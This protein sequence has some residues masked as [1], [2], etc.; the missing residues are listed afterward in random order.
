MKWDSF[1]NGKCV[2]SMQYINHVKKW[3]CCN[4]KLDPDLLL[5]LHQLHEVLCSW[6]KGGAHLLHH[7]LHTLKVDAWVCTRATLSVLERLQSHTHMGDSHRGAAT[8]RKQLYGDTT[9]DA[10]PTDISLSVCEESVEFISSFPYLHLTGC[11]RAFQHQM[12]PIE[13]PLIFRTDRKQN[14]QQ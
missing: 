9:H 8:E 14:N 2:H 12:I 11:S 6:W 10:E 1:H 3:I 13:M 7:S 5:A 4:K